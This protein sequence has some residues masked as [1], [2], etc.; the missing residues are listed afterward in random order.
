MSELVVRELNVDL[1][2]K[3]V[4]RDI[5]LIARAGEVIGL[6]GPNGAGKTTLLKAICRLTAARSGTVSW[7]GRAIEAMDGRTRAQTLA[8]LPQGH[9]VHWPMAVRRVVELGR[10]PGLGAFGKPSAAD[11]A[12]VDRAMAAA[13]LNALAGR[14]TASLSGGEQARVMLARALAVEAP[15]LL[16]DE[17]TASLDPYH[18][19]EIMELLRRSAGQG[20]L[21]IVVMHDL[22]LVA[23]FCDRVVLLDQGRKVA[24]GA[25]PEVLTPQ[26]L[27]DVYRIELD[28][29]E[30]AGWALAR[31]LATARRIGGD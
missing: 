9:V 31:A 28:A 4:L 13:D 18:A 24:D 14:Q 2:G 21:V 29:E 6:I 5:D 27:R 30:S 11:G 15:V 25:P 20:A 12:A 7:D 23:R 16:A 22:G 1:D 8:Y 26:R 3:P 10:L 17:P 19:L